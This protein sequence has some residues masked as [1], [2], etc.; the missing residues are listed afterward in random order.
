MDFE[1]LTFNTV[2]SAVEASRDNEF[3]IFLVGEH[4]Y[5]ECVKNVNARKIFVLQEDGAS[6][7]KEYELVSKYQSMENLVSEILEKY[8]VDESCGSNIKCGK[9]KTSLIT[10]YSPEHHTAQSM[11][12][13][14]AS[15]ILAEKGYNVLYL[16]LQGFSGFEELLNLSYDADITD[17]MY[18]VLK[19]SEKLLYKLEG[20]KRN[21]RGVD[22]LPPALDFSDLV[23]IRAE[24]WERALDLVMYSG[25]YTH[26]VVDLSEN[27]QG[28]Y[29]IL[30]RS[31]AVY[32]LYNDASIYGRA[33]LGHFRNLLEAKE[34]NK[35]ID[36]L[37]TYSIPCEVAMQGA[38]PQNLASSEIGAYMRGVI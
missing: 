15:Q 31:D 13:L 25:D 29:E 5:D 28:F 9:N 30:D 37:I 23:E 36:K 8:A 10:F 38:S 21:I 6:Q 4:T 27:C 26:I 2:K 32:V 20:M 12:A 33:A 22:Y 16:N 14:A 35:I 17:F 19:H 34:R 3:E 11:T 24:D 7:I 1:I 18:F